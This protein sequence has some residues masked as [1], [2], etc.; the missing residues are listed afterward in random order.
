MAKIRRIGRHALGALRQL[1]R[2]LP[3]YRALR[4]AP[5]PRFALRWRDSLLCLG[6]ATASTRFDRHYVFHTAWAARVL[7]RTRP[8]LHTD[9]SSSLYFVTGASAFV[10]VRF[11]D[12]RPAR[13]DLSG[14]ETQAADLCALPFADASI[15]SLSCMH[16][17]EHV[18]LGRYG[19]P[20]DYDGDLKAA[21]ELQ[22]VL[23]P[24]G[25]LLFVVPLGAAPRIQFNAHRIYTLALVQ[26]MFGGLR[27]HEFALIP[28]REEDGALVLAPDPQLLARQRYGCGCFW[29]VKDRQ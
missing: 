4:A 24:G 2:L 13:L 8:A 6:D 27:L 18:G 5:H 26:Q 20:I 16:V 17:V 10:P 14:L 23:A 21:A 19:D 12:Y 15:A 22:R 25:Q 28:D 9:I 11:F 29:F 7:A 1:L 3:Q